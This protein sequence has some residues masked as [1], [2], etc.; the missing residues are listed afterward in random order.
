MTSPGAFATPCESSDADRRTSGA[1]SL[2]SSVAADSMSWIERPPPSTGPPG[3]PTSHPLPRGVSRCPAWPRTS[4][5]PDNSTP[6]SRTGLSRPFTGRH[7]KAASRWLSRCSGSSPLR[8]EACREPRSLK[9][10]ATRRRMGSCSE[11]LLLPVKGHACD[12]V[13]TRGGPGAWRPHS[14]AL[15]PPWRR[16]CTPSHNKGTRPRHGRP[17]SRLDRCATGQHHGRG[18][19]RA[20]RHGLFVSP[21]Q[22]GGAVSRIPPGRV[23][24]YPSGSRGGTA[25]RAIPRQWAWA[26][27]EWTTW[28]HDRGAGAC[29]G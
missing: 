7:E 12:R 17:P 5:M 22:D 4:L 26:V 2:T 20:S 28:T 18:S 9:G 13:A 21:H 19:S 3:T 1:A 27:W 14:G 23:G 6:T 15:P 11:R 16:R 24:D 8:V 25:L 10:S 29:M